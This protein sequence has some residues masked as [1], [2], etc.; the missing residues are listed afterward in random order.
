VFGAALENLLGL[1]S[2]SSILLNNGLAR[3]CLSQ[4][5][6][7]LSRRNHALRTA[8][9][10]LLEDRRRYL[11]KLIKEKL[12]FAAENG[13]TIFIECDDCDDV[14]ELKFK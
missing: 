4:M 13:N 3:R 14:I 12:A 11:K 8:S 7:E 10:D 6:L 5:S 9:D 2:Q 1:C